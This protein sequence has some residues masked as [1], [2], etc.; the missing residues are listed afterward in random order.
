MSDTTALTAIRCCLCLLGPSGV[1]VSKVDGA[2]A[3]EG[4]IPGPWHGDHT[5]GAAGRD[6]QDGAIPSTGQVDTLAAVVLDERVRHL[7]LAVAVEWAG[8]GD[9]QKPCTSPSN[10]TWDLLR[11]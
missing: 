10:I 4:A 11:R 1:S 6:R 7:D 3:H 2:P 5:V 9:L 8:R